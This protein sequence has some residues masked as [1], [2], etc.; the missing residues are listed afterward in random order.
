MNNISYR[1]CDVFLIYINKKF[2]VPG[3]QDSLITR[4][5]PKIKQGYYAA[6]ILL[7]YI[8]QTISLKTV[9]N[10]YYYTLFQDPRL[11]GAMKSSCVLHVVLPTVGN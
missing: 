5:D 2:H 6:A 8:L 11:N 3:S 4:I 1:N 7:L 9:S 10:I